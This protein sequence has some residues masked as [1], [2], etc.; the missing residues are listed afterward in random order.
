MVESQEALAAKLAVI[1]KWGKIL[2]IVTFVMGIGIGAV[3]V[4]EAILAVPV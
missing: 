2:T 1:D 3:Y 4:Y